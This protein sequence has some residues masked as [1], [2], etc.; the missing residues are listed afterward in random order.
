MPPG[1]GGIGYTC[2][3]KILIINFFMQ[4]PLLLVLQKHQY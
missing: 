1:V 3:V 2:I 4:E